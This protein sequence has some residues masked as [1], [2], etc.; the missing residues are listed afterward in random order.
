MH[1]DEEI[2]GLIDRIVAG[3]DIASP[4][5]RADLRRE[6]EAHF[7]D[8]GTDGR[9]RLPSWCTRGGGRSLRLVAL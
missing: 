8:A 1:E 7:E 2:R 5:A 6:L 9:L 3:S 4:A